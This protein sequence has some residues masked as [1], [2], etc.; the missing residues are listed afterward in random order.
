MLWFWIIHIER[1][2]MDTQAGARTNGAWPSWKKKH[3]GRKDKITEKLFGD[4][5]HHDYYHYRLYL[6]RSHNNNTT[7]WCANMMMIAVTGVLSYVR[8]CPPY[9]C[10]ECLTRPTAN[11]IHVLHES[12]DSRERATPD[13]VIDSK[14]ENLRN[15]EARTRVICV[16][17]NE[18][19][20][21]HHPGSDYNLE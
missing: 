8:H 13:L 19:I 6:W 9:R 20:D 17:Y 10:N 3:L 12:P 16:V 18:L 15:T 11:S 5:C 7:D 14:C 1:L 4:G 2:V 21:G